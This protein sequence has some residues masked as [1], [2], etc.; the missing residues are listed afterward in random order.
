[1]NYI[2]FGCS[3]DLDPTEYNNWLDWKD[4]IDPQFEII[5]REI[6][7]KSPRRSCPVCGE[8]DI[9]DCELVLN[10]G[11]CPNCESVLENMDV[12]F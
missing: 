9:T 6:L 8:S 12:P 5:H 4:N 2:D 1:M 3:D 11:K 7:D 10:K